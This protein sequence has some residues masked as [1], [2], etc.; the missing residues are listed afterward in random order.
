MEQNNRLLAGARFYQCPQFK[1]ALQSE[2]RAKYMTAL[3]ACRW[4][5]ALTKVVSRTLWQAQQNRQ[6]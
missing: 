2:D 5:D 6:M 1:A 3:V 4:E